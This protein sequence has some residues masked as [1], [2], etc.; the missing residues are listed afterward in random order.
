MV[1][2]DNPETYASAGSV[3]EPGPCEVNGCG[4]W[5]ACFLLRGLSRRE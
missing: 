5:F 1:A 2:D 4:C 3:P